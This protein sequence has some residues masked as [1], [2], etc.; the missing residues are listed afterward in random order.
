M[1]DIPHSLSSHSYLSPHRGPPILSDCGSF[2][3]CFFFALTAKTHPK[4]TTVSISFVFYSLHRY[5]SAQTWTPTDGWSLGGSQGSFGSILSV[6]SPAHW[7]TVCSL[8]AEPTSMLC[9][10]WPPPLK[11]LA[12]LQPAIAFCLVPSH[13]PHRTLRMK[14]AENNWPRAH[15][16]GNWGFP[17]Q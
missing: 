6:H 11:G 4:A 2:F 1:I 7:A 9:S 16:H 5:V 12:S 14:S 13:G 10:S 3:V 8:K 17:G 15:S